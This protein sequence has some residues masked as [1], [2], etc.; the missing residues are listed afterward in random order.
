MWNTG[1]SSMSASPEPT[2]WLKAAAEV[3]TEGNAEGMLGVRF[4]W[5]P[6]VGGRGE[7]GGEGGHSSAEMNPPI[8]SASPAEGWE[9]GGE[10]EKPLP[11]TPEVAVRVRWGYRSRPPLEDSG[12][13]EEVCEEVAGAGEGTTSEEPSG[14]ATGAASSRRRLSGDI[15]EV[16]EATSRSSSSDSGSDS[17][18]GGEG[19]DR[20]FPRRMICRVHRSR[21]GMR[22][23][24]AGI[25]APEPEN[26]AEWVRLWEEGRA[27]AAKGTAISSASVSI[28]GGVAFPPPGMSTL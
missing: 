11:K 4:R 6:T 9:C 10:V 27:A 25:E 15:E 13:G 24:S 8:G 19:E 1:P 7:E 21:E 18:E 23:P 16:A 3:I 2:L 26:T 14:E 17:E 12:G 22:S 5:A 28:G 20:P